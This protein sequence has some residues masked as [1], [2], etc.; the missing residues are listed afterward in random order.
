MVRTLLRRRGGQLVLRGRITPPFARRAAPIVLERFRSCTD[1]ERVHT[2]ATLPPSVG[3][4][5]DLTG[6]RAELRLE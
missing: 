1:R 3:R 4:V 6:A 5:L 2:L